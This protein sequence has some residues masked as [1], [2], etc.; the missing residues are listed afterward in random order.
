MIKRNKIFI[1]LAI[2]LSI[3]FTLGRKVDFSGNVRD[4]YPINY[5]NDFC[6]EDLIFFAIA[7]IIICI[8]LAVI[9]HYRED[10]SLLLISRK[11]ISK[12]MVAACLII[13]LFCWLPYIL[14]FAP[15]SVQGDSLN[16]IRQIQEGNYNNHHPVLYTLFLSI[17]I[18][19]GKRIGN[20]NVG[21]F[22]YTIIQTTIMLSGIAYV[23]F[24]LRKNYINK[25]FIGITTIYF[26]LLSVFPSYAIVL[27]KDP[28]FSIALL[29]LSIRLF[30]CVTEKG[31]ETTCKNLIIIDVLCLTI[32]FFRNNGVYII[33]AT[34][35]VLF[36][37]FKGKIKYLV[38]NIF[39]VVAVSLIVQG[40]IYD[41]AGV[42]K[43]QTEAFGIPIQQIAAVVVERDE[44]VLSEN[45]KNV[46]YSLIP[47]DKIIENYTPGRVDDIKF[48]AEFDDEYLEKHKVEILNVWLELLPE[49][50]ITYV[51]AYVSET[52]GF[53]YPC[54]QNEYGY[55]SYAVFDNSYQIYS[56]DIIEKIFGHSIKKYLE[57][58]YVKL[59]SGLLIWIMLISM[60]LCC[61]RS[62]YKKYVGFLPPLFCWLAILCATP[63]AFSL[64]YV[65]VLALELPL[66]I[67]L[68][69]LQV[70]KT[71]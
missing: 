56:S 38:L 6:F 54:I 44:K 5:M 25:I 14:T 3:F 69:F 17:F 24:W 52:F 15:G 9:S 10:L 32:I 30:D 58:D 8:V 26:A 12:K 59:G 45:Q 29:I 18:E 47:R 7:V 53:W 65:Y 35:V 48:N 1:G 19:I 43:A 40:P 34:V 55:T 4:K 20:I 68:P 71:D 22:F 21:I 23:L 27:W 70:K 50:F 60:V 33:V 46:I 37:M 51:K 61:K 13:I 11:K 41:M 49:N 28:I 63:V 16:S 36:L 57:K 67:V 31:I 62:G 42:E 39:I 66:F 64:R 2:L